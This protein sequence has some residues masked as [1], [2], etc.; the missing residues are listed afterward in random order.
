[1]LLD[2]RRSE[3]FRGRPRVQNDEDY[4]QARR[5]RQQEAVIPAHFSF[6]LSFF[7]LLSMR[8]RPRVLHPGNARYKRIIEAADE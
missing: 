8:L 6:F 4:R 1:M 2:D 3:Q 5:E 7:L